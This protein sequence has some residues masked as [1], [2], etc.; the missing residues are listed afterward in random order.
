MVLSVIYSFL[1]DR[2]QAADYEGALTV[3]LLK[4]SV[5]A[6]LFIPLNDYANI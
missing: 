4:V 5:V 3:N 1:A 2:F 6:Q